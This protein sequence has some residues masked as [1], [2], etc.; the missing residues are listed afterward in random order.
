MCFL[1]LFHYRCQQHWIQSCFVHTFKMLHFFRYQVNLLIELQYCS[2]ILTNI[3]LW[4]TG[5]TF[6]VS[7]YFLEDLLDATDHIIEEDSKYAIREYYDTTKASLMITG[8]GG[9]K[10]KEIVTLYPEINSDQISDR[11]QG[12]KLSTQR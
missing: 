3:F 12:Y 7:E 5:R 8:R 1:C 11:Y 10:R 2:T 6:P 4:F 9:E